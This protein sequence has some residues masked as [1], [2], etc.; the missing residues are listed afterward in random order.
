MNEDPL[1]KDEQQCYQCIIEQLE[2]SIRTDS[3]KSVSKT[4]TGYKVT[5]R[6]NTCCNSPRPNEET[7][8]ILN[9]YISDNLQTQLN[10]HIYNQRSI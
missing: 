6:T 5:V 4:D 2:G 9:K 3:I 8:E 7:F 1:Y 10:K